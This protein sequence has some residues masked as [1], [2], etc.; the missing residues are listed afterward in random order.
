[1]GKVEGQTAWQR[2]GLEPTTEE[3]QELRLRERL[4]AEEVLTYAEQSRLDALER[5]EKLTTRIGS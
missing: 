4:K 1:M 5:K 3:M 2:I